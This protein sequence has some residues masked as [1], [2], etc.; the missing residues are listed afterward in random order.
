MRAAGQ[1]RVGRCFR[2][3]ERWHNGRLGHAAPVRA[4]R[5]TSAYVSLYR[6]PG[7]GLLWLVESPVPKCEGPGAPSSAVYKA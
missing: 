5:M 6:D 7:S 1:S 2:N 4:E 3:I